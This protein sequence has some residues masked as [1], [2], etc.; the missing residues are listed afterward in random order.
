MA[1][2]IVISFPIQAGLDV[3]ILHIPN[4][5]LPKASRLRMYAYKLKLSKSNTS[6]IELCECYY[7]LGRFKICWPE[8]S[9]TIKD[10][11]SFS[12]Q[13][14]NEIKKIDQLANNAE[15]LVEMF[16]AQVAKYQLR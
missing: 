11:T 16:I 8:Q 1:S 7:N 10:P 6:Y 4:Y 3:K 9:H 15:K 13:L 2:N 14:C 12:I 5:K